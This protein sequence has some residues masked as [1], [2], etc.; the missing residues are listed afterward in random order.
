MG[1]SKLPARFNTGLNEQTVFSHTA[2]NFPALLDVCE[3]L[4]RQSL[5]KV[6]GRIERNA[7]GQEEF[8]IP[9]EEPVPS[10][11]QL[12]WAPGPIANSRYTEA[13]MQRITAGPS[14][15]FIKFAPDWD[16]KDCG[17][18]MNPGLKDRFRGKKN[19]YLTHPLDRQTACVLSRTLEVP[20]G[21]TTRLHLVGPARRLVQGPPVRSKFLAA[22][23]IS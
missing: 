8:V 21:K 22:K 3:K 11:L 20:S 16:M 12:T 23:G 17:F 4:T 15:D 7:L 18:Y 10:P 1:F 19:V 13:E 5:L 2:Y 14:F 6:G 9:V